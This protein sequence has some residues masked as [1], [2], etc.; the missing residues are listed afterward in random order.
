MYTEYV[1]KIASDVSGIDIVLD[2][3]EK[4][5][6]FAKQLKS[7]QDVIKYNDEMDKD[8]IKKAVNEVLDKDPVWFTMKTRSTST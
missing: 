5:E 7:L 4:Y 1:K 8:V 2:T 6:L 3:D